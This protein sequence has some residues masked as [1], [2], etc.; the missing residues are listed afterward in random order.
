MYRTH[1]ELMHFK[2]PKYNTKNCLGLHSLV[3][4][5]SQGVN[6]CFLVS[7]CTVQ[8]LEGYLFLS[9]GIKSSGFN[10]RHTKLDCR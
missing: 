5:G 7:H 2:V 6:P 8:P 4:Q 9:F 3:K 1:P 10:S